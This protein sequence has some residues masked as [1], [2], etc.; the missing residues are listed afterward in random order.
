[1]KTKIAYRLVVKLLL[2]VF[3]F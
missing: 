2:Y 1:V 3:E